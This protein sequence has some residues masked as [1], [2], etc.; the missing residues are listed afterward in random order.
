MAAFKSGMKTVIIPSQNKPDLEKIDP[1]VKNSLNFIFADNF[2]TV[3]ENALVFDEEIRKHSDFSSLIT[4]DK[5][6]NQKSVTI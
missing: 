5:M 6:P 2:S 3:I 4:S 1:T